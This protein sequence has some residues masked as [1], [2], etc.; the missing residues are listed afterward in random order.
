MS[1]SLIR[2]GVSYSLD[3]Y[4]TAKWVEHEDFGMVGVRRFSEQGPNQHGDTD[5]GFRLEPAFFTMGFVVR[6]AS[7]E[8][9]Q[10]KK[11]RFLALIGTG[12]IALERSAGAIRRRL[13]CE[14]Y[15]KPRSGSAQHYPL[16]HS[17][18]IVAQFKASDP[19]WFDP[20][21]SVVNL[22]LTVAGTPWDIPWT[23]EPWTIG[24]SELDH[25][26]SLPYPGTWASSPIIR[27]VGP[28]E[29]PVLINT[30][31]GEK[32]SLPSAA[33]AAGDYRIID[34]RYGHHT[35]VDSTGAK[36]DFELSE[37]SDLTSFHLAP[38]PDAPGGI[39]VFTIAGGGATDATAAF[40][41]YYVRYFGG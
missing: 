14:L 27:I 3:D 34:T 37:D 31:T 40:L 17:Q 11:E 35:I 2:N 26:F 39:N 33:I 38:D 6:G 32:I 25:T 12:S 9:L 5:L 10:T 23:I 36:K 22:G 8:E 19:S 21:T 16:S 15:G 20:E 28:L 41:T 30:T 4:T 18:R 13:D 1:L 7:D 29:E 24:A